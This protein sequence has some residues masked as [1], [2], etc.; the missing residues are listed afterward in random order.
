MTVF[1]QNTN[2]AEA[3]PTAIYSPPR[4]GINFSATATRLLPCALIVAFLYQWS[5]QFFVY[6]NLS[7]EGNYDAGYEIAGNVPLWFRYPQWLMFGLI[8]VIACCVFIAKL[9]RAVPF[10]FRLYYFGIWGYAAVLLLLLTTDPLPYISSVTPMSSKMA[11]AVLIAIS[12][13]FLAANPATWPAVLRSIVI[14]TA[15]A[16]FFWLYGAMQLEFASRHF[17]Y[18]WL[19]SPTLI[20]EITSMLLFAVLFNKSLPYKIVSCIPISLLGLS[21]FFQQT[22]LLIVMF[23]VQVLTYAYL[24][25]RNTSSS[26]RMKAVVVMLLLLAVGGIFMMTSDRL[27]TRAFSRTTIGESAQMLANR[28]TEDTRSHQLKPFFSRFWE[29]FPLGAGYPAI[30][31]Y[32]AE[33]EYGID[34]G[35]LNSMYVT[36]LP[37]MLCF[38]GMLVWPVLKS[39]RLRLDPVDAAVVAGAF[40]YA[41]RLLSSTVPNLEVTFLLFILLAGRC[42]YLAGNMIL[43]SHAARYRHYAA[44]TNRGEFS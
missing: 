16:T 39:L 43:P 30:D 10:R 23:F 4:S 27:D 33:G 28:F 31:E 3:Q 38:V 8:V 1:Q 19:W 25:Y 44:D 7:R 26:Q 32:N 14:V 18:R 5:A 37:M 17:A 12:M 34:C 11:P 41:V 20:L 36:G 24:R 2:A 40:A 42:A 22:R 6:A 21:I 35:Y 15:I 9:Y 13:F 29:S